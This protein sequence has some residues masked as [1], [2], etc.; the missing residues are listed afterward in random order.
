MAV[1]QEADVSIMTRMKTNNI[2][3][4]IFTHLQFLLASYRSTTINCESF[5]PMNDQIPP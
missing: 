2:Q 4:T 5:Y 1:I 3:D